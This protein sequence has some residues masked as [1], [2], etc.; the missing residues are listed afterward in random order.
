MFFTFFTPSPVRAQCAS[1]LSNSIS[2]I[3]APY[4]SWALPNNKGAPFKKTIFEGTARPK[5]FEIGPGPKWNPTRYRKI[6]SNNTIEKRPQAKHTNEAPQESKHLARSLPEISSC[7]SARLSVCLSVCPPCPSVI[8]L[9]PFSRTAP[10]H[11]SWS[12]ALFLMQTVLTR[13][14]QEAR[15]SELCSIKLGTVGLHDRS[16]SFF[17]VMA[18][19]S[20][21]LPLSW[22]IIIQLLDILFLQ[23]F[24]M[25][26]YIIAAS[27]GSRCEMVYEPGS[28]MEYLKTYRTSAII[29]IIYNPTINI[30]N[31]ELVATHGSEGGKLPR[32]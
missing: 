27:L 22:I 4:Q 19:P 24:K 21:P 9:L 7:P 14:I 13:R 10:L 6:C 31:F 15:P 16:E 17:A 8:C 25:K 11:S 12:T 26:H 23:R 29:H 18:L 30:M 3:S 28:C 2:S 20:E 1:A 32:A 5:M